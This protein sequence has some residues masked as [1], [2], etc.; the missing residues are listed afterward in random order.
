MFF[1]QKKIYF[2]PIVITIILII[3]HYLN[4]LTP[5]ENGVMI[6]LRPFLSGISHV[7][8]SI[9]KTHSNLTTKVDL[10]EKLDK[11]KIENSLLIRENQRLK[12]IKQENNKLR[13]FVNFKA[14][15]EESL[16]LANVIS[17]PTANSPINSR[18]ILDKG[19]KDGI[20]HGLAVVDSNGMMIGK[21]IDLKNHTAKICLITEKNCELA[22]MIQGDQITSGISNGELN[23][24][25][26]MNY[27]PQTQPIEL[28]DIVVTSG[29]E[30]NIPAGLIIGN[31]VQ[32]FQESNDV[33]KSAIIEPKS[34]LDNI[35]IV[36]IIL[37]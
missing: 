35:G 12:Y 37:P 1:P 24:I 30:S 20:I 10:S 15:L 26:K 9:A 14:S 6:V 3:L 18:V 5:L 13:S 21:I 31:V 33:W 22:V 19:I 8:S 4:I 2:R 16:M 11:L 34:K 25:T 23:L 28:E 7:S 17:T 29:L 27:I 32:I 36:A